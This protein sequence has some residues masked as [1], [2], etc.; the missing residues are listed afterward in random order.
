MWL[1]SYVAQAGRI[2]L[3]RFEYPLEL[4]IRRYCVPKAGKEAITVP[5]TYSL[6]LVHTYVRKT[7]EILS[8]QT[9]VRDL[10]SASMCRWQMVDQKNRTK[11][12]SHQE[13]FEESFGSRKGRRML[14]LVYVRAD[15]MPERHSLKH[16]AARAWLQQQPLRLPAELPV[17]L[18]AYLDQIERG[19]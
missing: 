13:A 18:K 19:E 10:E 9:F 2:V 17:E 1:V 5:T 15:V 14:G 3:I 8:H 16:R 11:F 12:C 6:A 7:K 4:D